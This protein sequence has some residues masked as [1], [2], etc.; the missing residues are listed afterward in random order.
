MA[1]AITVRFEI[2]DDDHDQLVA[3]SE[4]E[5][6]S[7]AQLIQ[8]AFRVYVESYTPSP[9]N[10]FTNAALAAWEEGEGC[11]TEKSREVQA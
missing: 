5:Q 9:K 4:T 2:T 6:I 7:E 1:H 3:I 11:Q 8:R 10:P